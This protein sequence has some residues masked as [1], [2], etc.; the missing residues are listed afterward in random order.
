MVIHA[1][2]VFSHGVYT[3]VFL[4]IDYTQAWNV[5]AHPEL[6]DKAIIVSYVG[7]ELITDEFNMYHVKFTSAGV[8]VSEADKQDWLHMFNDV[9]DPSKYDGECYVVATDSL[10]AAIAGEDIL[11]NSIVREV[12]G[13]AHA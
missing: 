8:S 10:T 7:G 5:R 2:T 11:R 13:Y 6:R 3:I 9:C 12:D 1:V 4:T